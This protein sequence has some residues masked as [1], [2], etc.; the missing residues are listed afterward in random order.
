MKHE[1]KEDG[2]FCVRGIECVVAWAR[3]GEAVILVPEMLDEWTVEPSATVKSRARKYRERRL[4][5]DTHK[6]KGQ[7]TDSGVEQSGSSRGP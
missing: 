2:V 1:V 7:N 4:C 3:A 5:I 6:G